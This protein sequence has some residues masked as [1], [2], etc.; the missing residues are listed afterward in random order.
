MKAQVVQVRRQHFRLE[1]QQ[2]KQK[3]DIKKDSEDTPITQHAN[4]SQRTSPVSKM[5]LR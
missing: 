5:K 1:V 4:K 2:G 3:K